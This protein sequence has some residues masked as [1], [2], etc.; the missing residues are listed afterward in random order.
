MDLGRARLLRPPLIAGALLAANLL[1]AAG[2][3]A[4]ALAPRRIVVLPAA[5]AE[6]EL[7]PGAV[8]DAAARE[9]ALRYV[10]AFDNYTPA[11][12]EAATD[13]LKRMLAGRRWSAVSEALDRRRRVVLEGRMASQALPLGAEVQGLR[14]TV[15][16]LRRTF[17]SD[18]L[19]REAR[20]SYVVEIEKQPATDANP[21]GLAVVSQD[22]REEER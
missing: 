22:I 17:V 11:T 8:P 19:S 3:V 18:R 16:A 4:G 2:L 1:L 7:W 5:R 6:A 12:I 10:L 21:F 14:V 20:V 15:R 13:V 9:F